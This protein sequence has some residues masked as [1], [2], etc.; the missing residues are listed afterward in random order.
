MGSEQE[1]G[2]QGNQ[3]TV[4]EAVP[5]PVPPPIILEGPF[6]LTTIGPEQLF[7]EALERAKQRAKQESKIKEKTEIPFEEVGDLLFPPKEERVR[8]DNSGIVHIDFYKTLKMKPK[9]EKERKYRKYT[10]GIE[11]AIRACLHIVD[12]NKPKGETTQNLLGIL[13][14]TRD[15]YEDFTNGQINKANL[16]QYVEKAYQ[17]LEESH[18]IKPRSPNR[19]AAVQ[20]ILKALEKDSNG[21]FNPL[22]SRSQ[23]GSAAIRIIEEIL[24]TGFVE[25]KYLFIASLLSLERTKERFYLDEVIKESKKYI[26]DAQ[27]FKT[28][29][30]ARESTIRLM[31]FFAT[32]LHPNAVQLKP[33]RQAALISV[34]FTFGF[35]S[36]SEFNNEWVES[37]NNG[38]EPKSAEEIKLVIA[39]RNK[40]RTSYRDIITRLQRTVKF[41]EKVLQTGEKDLNKYY[42]EVQKP[43]PSVESSVV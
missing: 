31:N 15:L 42:E 38:F 19:Q 23:L 27:K 33:Y 11:S 18:L 36:N 24:Y 2:L 5:D 29:K 25:K 8:I 26:D 22:K 4:I 39:E 40:N 17:K 7:L 28:I 13:D 34:A 6:R 32:Y 41:L 35:P 21:R 43:I 10:D 9:G 14:L 1:Q 37:I 30:R 16:A 12:K 3:N 20:K